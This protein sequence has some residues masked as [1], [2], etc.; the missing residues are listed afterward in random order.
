[1]MPGFSSKHEWGDPQVFPEGH[2]SART[3]WGVGYISEVLIE[4]V[5][6]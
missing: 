5:C 3:G 4:L 2:P 6:L 1:M